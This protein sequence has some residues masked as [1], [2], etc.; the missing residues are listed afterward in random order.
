MKTAPAAPVLKASKQEGT[1]DT[2]LVTKYTLTDDEG[3]HVSTIEYGDNGYR[4]SVVSYNEDGSIES[5]TRYTYVLDANGLWTSRVIEKSE[6]GEDADFYVESK[7]EREIDASMHLQAVKIYERGSQYDEESGLMKKIMYLSSFKMYEYS[8]TDDVQTDNPGNGSEVVSISYNSDGSISSQTRYRWFAPAK[9][10]LK[11]YETPTSDYMTSYSFNDNDGTYTQTDY[12]NN[13]TEEEPQWV[14]SNEEILYYSNGMP[15]GRLYTSYNSDGSVSWAS[16]QKNEYQY[17]TPSEGWTTRIDYNYDDDAAAFVIERKYEYWGDGSD[18][19]KAH[20]WK[21]NLYDYSDGVWRLSYAG[22]S[23]ILDNQVRRITYKYGNITS[24][25]DQKIDA[26][27]NII[28]EITYASDGSYMVTGANDVEGSALIYHY[29]AQNN[30]VQTVKRVEGYKTNVGTSTDDDEYTYYVLNNGI[31]EQ[32]Q[33]YETTKV[34]GDVTVRTVYKFTDEGYPLSISEY[35]KSPNYNDGAEVLNNSITYTYSSNGYERYEEYYNYTESEMWPDSRSS[36]RL[37][38]NGRYEYISYTYDEDTKG[39]VYSATKWEE[40]YGVRWY[41]LYDS[42]TDAF[43]FSYAVGGSET[44][45][46]EDGT[47]TTI[48]CSV[49][50]ND[51]LQYES[52]EVYKHVSTDNLYYT[53]RETY[54]W[55]ADAQK[56]VGDSKHESRDERFDFKYYEPSDP[57]ED[58]DDDFFYPS[59]ESGGTLQQPIQSYSNSYTWDTETSAWKTKY[60]EET[61]TSELSGNKLTVDFYRNEESEKNHTTH[62]YEVDDT[63]RLV[64]E[65]VNYTLEYSES[66]TTQ[67]NKTEYTYN[68][69]GLL[70]QQKETFTSTYDGETTV[71]VE[72]KDYEYGQYTVMVTDIDAP[73]VTAKKV[74]MAISGRTVSAPESTITLYSMDGVAVAQGIG[75]VTAPAAGLYVVSVDG[76]SVKIALK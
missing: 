44:T 15:A 14:K 11:S 69:Q 40:Q 52:K 58:Y 59:E 51:N 64:A 6:T 68:E 63:R 26:E 7:E 46:D 36:Y 49:D 47:E 73:T 17:D 71:T 4:K 55:D 1:A 35:A 62:I 39:K 41:Y 75:T 74:K 33:E 65:T 10:Y 50:D 13:G 61:F 22:E 25:V 57:M 67:S 23:A 16:G 66:T 60:S 12:R 54:A 28:G 48:S 76:T 32:K 45:V 24:T 21:E 9:D 20:N 29:D 37:L 18:N 8:H 53:L 19:D 34:L 42:S 3:K 43:T 70:T 72:V 2:L 56:W 5:K 27:G 30:L 38:D 31:W